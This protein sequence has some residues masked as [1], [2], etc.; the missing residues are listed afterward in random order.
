M[1]ELLEPGARVRVLARFHQGEVGEVVE[2]QGHAPGLVTVKFDDGELAEYRPSQLKLLRASEEM[3]TKTEQ[4]NKGDRVEVLWDAPGGGLLGTVLGFEGD[5]VVVE[6]DNGKTNIFRR[7]DVRKV[8]SRTRGSDIRKFRESYN[9]SVSRRESSSLDPHSRMAVKHEQDEPFDATSIF[10]DLNAIFGSGRWN[11]SAYNAPGGG[12]GFYWKHAYADVYVKFHR[13]PV[14]DGV[15]VEIGT[16]YAV[17]TEV[18]VGPGYNDVGTVKEEI[19]LLLK[20]QAA[21]LKAGA[22]SY[23]L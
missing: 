5:L 1:A 22:E 6:L 2:P 3:K 4:V 19:N 15:N 10:Q 18:L 9:R 20:D 23:K 7:V 21:A 16:S 17:D 13:D 11:L 8:E 12:S 14:Y